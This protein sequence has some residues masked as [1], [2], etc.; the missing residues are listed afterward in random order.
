MLCGVHLCV[1]YVLSIY[2]DYYDRCV[3]FG[4]VFFFKQKTAYEMRISDWSSDVCSSDLA[5]GGVMRPA[6]DRCSAKGGSPAKARRGV[7]DRHP[8]AGWDPWT[9]PQERAGSRSSLGARRPARACSRRGSSACV[10]TR[11]PAAG[12][13]VAARLAGSP[14]SKIGRAHV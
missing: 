14:M 3:L 5:A 10:S 8:R 4:V 7:T 11:C 2:Y 1:L 13:K 12:A 6:G 9:L